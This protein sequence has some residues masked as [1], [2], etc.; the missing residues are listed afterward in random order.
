MWKDASGML[1]W[2]SQSAY[3]TMIWQTY[4]Y[5][6]DLTGAY[7]GAKTACEPVHIQW[8]PAT[9]SVKVINNKPYHKTG[10]IAEASVYNMNGQIVP[11]YSIKKQINVSA[12]S[13]TEA[14]KVFEKKADLP[15]LS[16]VHFLKLK[17][18][19]TKGKLLSE[20]FYWM[21]NTY[22]DYTSLND[23]PS[24]GPNLSVSRPVIAIAKNGV[25]KLLKYI[26]VNN[27]KTTAAFGI[28][29]QLLNNAGAQLLPALYNDGYFSLM[30]GETKMLEVEI[31]PKLLNG[32]Y[33]LQVKAYNN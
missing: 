9:N 8:N 4:D 24:V 29:A 15:K 25:N 21:G 31:D 23:M 26:I 10:V 27:S 1:I 3:P 11:G 7:F 30:R 18:F 6:Y 17:L 5:Y 32:G 33:K 13:A 19:D 28:R 22:L 14:F 2:M 12:T 16:K 20:N